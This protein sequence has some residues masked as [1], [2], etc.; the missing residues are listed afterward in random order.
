[1]TWKASSGWS[2]INAEKRNNFFKTSGYLYEEPVNLLM[3]EFRSIHTYHTVL[4][5]CASGANKVNE[6]A[7]KAH[8]STATLAYVLRGLTEIGI[9]SRRSPMTEKENRRKT[10][11][12]ISDGMYR[13]WYCF[14]PS[15]RAS[16]EMDRGEVFYH[17]YVKEKLHNYMGGIFEEMCRQYTLTQGLDG[18][19]NCLVTNV[20]SWWGS[21]QDH[22]PTDIDV[23]GIDDV[24]KKAVIGECKFRNEVIDKEVYDALMNRRGLI[25]RHYE[26]A[27]YLFFSLSGFSK[28]VMENVQSD[29][30]RLL[31]LK[32]LYPEEHEIRQ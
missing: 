26:E 10:S 20:G 3:Q 14:V 32:D 11:Y 16:I 6:I 5:V 31:T 27:E 17:R 22:K 24:S 23:V 18:K 4:E 1:M 28:W 30:V 19:L 7:D 15:A 12:E 29:S 13:F 25:D 21:G 2:G 8:I 9:L